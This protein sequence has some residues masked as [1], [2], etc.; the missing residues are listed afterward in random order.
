MNTSQSVIVLT[1]NPTVVEKA[2]QT[3]KGFKAVSFVHK[4]TPAIVKNVHW[5]NKNVVYD[6]NNGFDLNIVSKY[7]PIVINCIVGESK[8]EE[9]Q[10]GNQSILSDFPKLLDMLNVD[11]GDHECFDS[12]D[13][14]TVKSNCFICKVVA[15]EPDKPEHIL[16]ESEC[17]IVIPGLGAF[18]DGYVMIVP[19][20]HIMSFAELNNNEFEEFLRVLNDMKFILESVYKKKTFIFECG[21]GRNGGG[22]HK[23]SIVHA[24]IHMAST[25]MPVLEEVQKSGLHPAK[26]SPNDLIHDYGLYPYMLYIDQSNNWYITSDPQTYF[27]RQHPRQVL[28]DYMGLA[29][30]EYN[31]RT[32]PYRERLDIIAEEIYGFL[33]QEFKNLPVWIQRATEKYL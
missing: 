22:K 31:W 16:Y 11:T 4:L 9:M 25:D 1:G 27:P 20:R 7:R 23:T 19:K 8:F 28:A 17:F 14:N 13:S 32:H 5:H 26:I 2:V 21:S 3:I 12:K 15:G 18:F 10:L 33:R 6:A 30:G 24:H 29:K